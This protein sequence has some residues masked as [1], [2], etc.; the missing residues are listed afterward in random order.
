MT[1][2][3]IV[4]I[5]ATVGVV[6]LVCDLLSYWRIFSREPYQR[7]VEKQQREKWKVEKARAD[8]ER[9]KSQQQAAAGTATNTNKRGGAGANKADKHAKK[10]KRAEDDYADSAANVARR[11]TSPNILTSLVFLVLYRVLGSEHS[12]KVL[13]VLPFTPFPFLRKVTARGLDLTTVTEQTAADITWVSDKVTNTAQAV[14]FVF[15]YLLC[16]LSVK[17]YVGKLFGTKPPAGAENIM[18]VVNS[19]QGQKILQAVGIDEE[20]IVGAKKNL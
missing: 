6:Q 3:D 9:A 4:K 19:P 18:A 12:S 13:G 17:F 14:S 20:T 8:A 11:H 2:S 7:A 1:A 16:T 10:L 5:A 15:I